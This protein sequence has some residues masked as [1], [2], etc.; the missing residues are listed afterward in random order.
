[1]IF[2][3]R[4]KFNERYKRALVDA[5]FKIFIKGV[6]A[7]DS[8]RV[9]ELK[10]DPVQY[11]DIVDGRKT[12]TVRLDDRAYVERDYV[13]LR[14]TKYTGAQMKGSTGPDDSILPEDIKNKMPL[15]YMGLSTLCKIT[16]VYDGPGMHQG[17]VVLSLKIIDRFP[18]RVG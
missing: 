15:V 8:A 6:N 4:R 14:K 9:H 10:S 1:M 2:N 7:M 17:F 5:V 18:G 12:H 16:N 13:I 11:Q 3:E